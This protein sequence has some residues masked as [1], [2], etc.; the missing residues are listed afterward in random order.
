MQ[1]FV[2]TLALITLAVAVRGEQGESDGQA[3]RDYF[4][5][6]GHYCTDGFYCL[7]GNCYPKRRCGHHGHC[8]KDQYCDKYQQ[9]CRKGVRR[10]SYH[11]Q[12]GYRQICKGGKCKERE[13]FG[14]RDCPDSDA[15]HYPPGICL[16][17]TAYC[18]EGYNYC[19]RGYV[20]VNRKCV[21]MECGSDFGC[22]IGDHCV[23]GFCKPQ[24]DFCKTDGDC[25]KDQCCVIKGNGERGGVCK[26]LRKP[27]DWCPLKQNLQACPCV[28]GYVCNVTNNVVWGKCQAVDG[29]SGSGSGSDDF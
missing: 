8:L 20:C 14:H 18:H 3:Q 27:G 25:S 11:N 24:K 12:C 5:C 10:C 9:V 2:A 22:K 1:F 6:G 19:K 26:S 13:C 28:S 15:C 23:G 4:Q 17:Y 16:A 29:G 7:H 21:K